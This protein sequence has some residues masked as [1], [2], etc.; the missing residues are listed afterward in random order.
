[1]AAGEPS[2]IRDRQSLAGNLFRYGPARGAFGQPAAAFRRGRADRA[3][4]RSAGLSEHVGS[5]RRQAR[6][7]SRRAYRTTAARARVARPRARS[8]VLTITGTVRNPAAA[9]KLEGLTA[10]VS[11]LDSNG[12]LVSTKDVPLD[13]R[14]LGP[15]EEAPFKV[16]RARSGLDRAVSCELPRRHRRGSACRSAHRHETG[17]CAAI[18]ALLNREASLMK[19][20]LRPW[21]GLGRRRSR[22]AWPAAQRG[23]TEQEDFRFSSGVELVNVTATVTDKTGRFVPGPPAGRLHRL[24]RERAS[25]GHALQQRARACQ[26]RH[27]ARHERQHGGREIVERPGGDRPVSHQAAP[28]RRRDL[29]LQIQQLSGSRAGLDDRSSAPQPQRSVG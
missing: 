16:Q 11:L 2:A 21:I 4:R 13:Y 14:A 9:S 19:H 7:R 5:E 24:R 12:A 8:D 27:R 26:P 29:S 3:A 18:G 1:M 25:E 23:G 22:R 28:T 20:M 6:P 10:V 15:G 17:K